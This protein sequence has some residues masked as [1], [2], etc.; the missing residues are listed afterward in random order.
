MIVVSMA[1]SVLTMFLYERSITRGWQVPHWLLS[2]SGGKH[3]KVHGKIE[4]F[5]KGLT[6]DWIQNAKSKLMHQ[7]TQLSDESVSI[8]RACL[9]Q[10]NGKFVF[11]IHGCWKLEA[12][13]RRWQA[14]VYTIEILPTRPDSSKISRPGPDHG[15]YVHPIASYTMGRGQRGVDIDGV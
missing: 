6:E 14:G 9:L 8:L 4:I 7:D 15:K 11:S 12:S 1:I 13:R 10:L 2:I 5:E 3:M